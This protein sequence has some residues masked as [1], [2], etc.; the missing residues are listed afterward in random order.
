M[1]A[2][3]TFQN[4]ASPASLRR[5]VF[6]I[7]SLQKGENAASP[8]NGVPNKNSVNALTLETEIR[9]EI[10]TDNAKEVSYC[11]TNPT[12]VLCINSNNAENRTIFGLHSILDIFRQCFY[13]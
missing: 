9:K 1:C 12:F 5:L 3:E 13:L 4:A 11:E 10:K 8:V 7:D 6:F 2:E